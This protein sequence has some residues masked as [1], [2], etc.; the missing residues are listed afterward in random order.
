MNNSF[1]Q[2]EGIFRRS[3]FLQTSIA[4]TL[5]F[6]TKPFSTMGA[7]HE[8]DILKTK[9]CS[10]LGIDF[11]VI[12][13]GMGGIAGPE[14][15]AK[16]SQSGGLGILTGTLLPPDELRKKIKKVK[17]LTGKPFGVNL[18]LHEDLMHPKNMAGL[19]GEDVKKT[20]TILNRFRQ[21]L[22]LPERNQAPQS[23]PE[24][25]RKSF[26]VI[27]EEKVP[28]FSIGLGNPPKDWVEECHRAG[29]KVIAMISTVEDA[30]AVSANNA[31]V[32]IAQGSEAG[33]HRSTWKKTDS[34]QKAAIGS[35]ALV[36]QVVDAVTQPVVAAGGIVDGRGLVAALSLGATGVL[37]GTRFIC[38]QESMAPDFYK[39]AILKNSNDNTIITNVFSGGYA[40]VIRNTFTEEYTKSNMPVYPP[41][42]QYNEAQDIYNAALE[43]KNTDYYTLWAGQGIGSFHD[44]PGAD[45]VL[46]NI[47]R[48]AKEV[49]NQFKGSK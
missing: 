30:K 45:T 34:G 29:I 22:G 16:I 41:F 32:I 27:L 14:L 11:P 25:L 46:K 8:K 7:M 1:R 35:M 42:I 3:R 24:T 47:I 43:Q 44:I 19:P 33:G 28:V 5:A 17:E 10:L 12:Q 20:Q 9:L 26:D 13:A 39:T 36:P 23:I 48:E 38:T 31:D 15:V 40:R 4:A 21:Q 18:L 6:L 49:L 2:K 37:I